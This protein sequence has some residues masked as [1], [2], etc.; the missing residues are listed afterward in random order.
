MAHYQ[1]T[2]VD[3]KRSPEIRMAFW[4]TQNGANFEFRAGQHATLSPRTRAWESEGDNSRPFRSQA[5]L[6][7]KSQS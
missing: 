2:L 3:R 6:I 1:M 5:L 4:S 7:D